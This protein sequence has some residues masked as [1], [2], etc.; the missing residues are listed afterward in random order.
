M[1]DWRCDPEEIAV[2]EGRNRQ[3]FRLFFSNKSRTSQVHVAPPLAVL[4][5]ARQGSTMSERC[6]H[7][8]ALTCS[9]AAK[10]SC[11]D[12]APG[13]TPILKLPI[14]QARHL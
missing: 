13:T 10:T 11:A 12:S 3:I 14:S 4:G 8:A 9:P 5:R 6:P 1:E 7:G 2:K